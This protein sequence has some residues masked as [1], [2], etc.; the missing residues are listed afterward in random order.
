R[1]AANT[2][3]WG[4]KTLSLN[5]NLA[6]YAV[7]ASLLGEYDPAFA[8]WLQEAIHTRTWT[9]WTDD[10][11]V[12]R[13]AMQEPSNGGC[14]ARASVTAIAL[15]TGD[16]ALLDEVANRFHDWLRRSAAVQLWDEK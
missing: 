12:Y 9:A 8:A 15:Y 3:V 4:M 11:T 2:D 7:A 10:W 6:G 16:A 5:R 13:S 1:E 14:H